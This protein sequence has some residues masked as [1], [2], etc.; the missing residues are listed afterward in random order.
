M[1]ATERL[2]E[3]AVPEAPRATDGHGRGRRRGRRGGRGRES[4]RPRPSHAPATHHAPAPATPAPHVPAARVAAET[5]GEPAGEA[6]TAPHDEIVAVIRELIER[7]SDGAITI[8]TLANALKSRGF[9]RTPGS[10]RLITRLRRIREITLDR[11]GR[12]TLVDGAASP[13][14][15]GAHHAPA[16]P[17]PTIV[18]DEPEPVEETRP[19]DAEAEEEPNFNRRQPEVEEAE[20]DEEASPGNEKV[21]SRERRPEP[22]QA[23]ERRRRRSRRGGRGRRHGR[24]GAPAAS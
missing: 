19:A 24:S 2:A 15:H 7:A 16:P 3:H 4:E 21:P 20:E 10:P 18:P 8:D 9:R 6:H 11:T 22:A 13:R 12:I 14:G 17:P 5:N 23:A 1:P